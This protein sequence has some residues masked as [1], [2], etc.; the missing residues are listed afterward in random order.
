M[1]DFLPFP[2]HF[3]WGSAASGH[4]IE[5]NNKHSDWWHWEL[6]TNTQPNSGKAVD[7]WNRFEEDHALM[8]S[9]GHQAFRL[10][11]EWA[12]IEPK[13]G[14]FDADAVA[15]YHRILKSLQSHGIKICLTLHHWVLPKWVADEKDWRNPKTVEWFLRYTDFAIREFGEY[16]DQWITLNEPMVAALAGYFSADFPPGRRNYF[17]LRNVVRNMLKAHA[18]AYQLIHEYDPAAQVGIAMSYPLL[19]PWG[20]KG[21][22]GWYERM[23]VAIGRRFVFLAWDE[24]VKTGRVHPLYGR[25][26]IKELRESIDFCGINYYFRMTLRFSL[27]HIRTGFI[28]Q[29]ATP[30]G[31]DKNDFGW[32]IWPEGIHTIISEVWN[33]FRKPIY[34]TENGIAD[35]SDKKRGAYISEHLKQVHRSIEDGVPVQG[36]YHWSFIDNFEWKEGFDMRFG[37]VE[38]DPEDPE[39]KRTP[40]RSASLYSRIIRANGIE[41]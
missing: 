21:F 34:I 40:R 6:A 41:I 37:L 4:Q 23:T 29:E 16:P 3:L 14:E 9:M 33:R 2:D 24:S 7:Y 10:G 38:V 25:G 13:P 28:D 26:T 39:L 27:R 35:A 8:A 19:E 36:Y 17:E 12:R 18:G 22:A 30:D 31:V 11:I 32:Q 1:S 15:H 5:G 20:S